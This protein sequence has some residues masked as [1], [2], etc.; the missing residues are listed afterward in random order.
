MINTVIC[1]SFVFGLYSLGADLACQSD[2]VLKCLYR[3]GG[4]RLHTAAGEGDLH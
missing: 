1:F 2:P 3:A 4:Q